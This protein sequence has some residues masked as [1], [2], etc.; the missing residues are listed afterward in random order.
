MQY[1]TTKIDVISLHQ[2]PLTKSQ[3]IINIKNKIFHNAAEYW[4]FLN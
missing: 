1:Y 4:P 2:R 3:S